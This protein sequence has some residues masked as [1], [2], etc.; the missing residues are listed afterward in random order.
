MG[1]GSVK[2]VPEVMYAS[3]FS[4]GTYQ[5]EF[6]SIE[7]HVVDWAS[8]APADPRQRAVVAASR[9][10]QDRVQRCAVE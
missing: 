8:A 5:Y 3:R 1:V 2:L 4:R 10:R 6:D 7:S 9:K